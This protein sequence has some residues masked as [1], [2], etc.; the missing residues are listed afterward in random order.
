MKDDLFGFGEW[1]LFYDIFEQH[2]EMTKS[3]ALMYKLMEK[4]F[5]NNVT[6]NL[7]YN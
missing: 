1:E 4:V 6:L 7:H 2:S 5:K 3:Q